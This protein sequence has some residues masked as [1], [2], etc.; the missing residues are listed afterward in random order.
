MILFQ[1]ENSGQGIVFWLS[2]EAQHVFHGSKPNP[3]LS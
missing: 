1:L 3:A 2:V